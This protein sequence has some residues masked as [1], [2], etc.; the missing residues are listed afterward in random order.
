MVTA[1][2]DPVEIAS[3]AEQAPATLVSHGPIVPTATLRLVVAAGIVARLRLGA[4]AAGAS[5]E[6]SGRASRSAVDRLAVLLGL[7][8]GLVPTVPVIVLY[9][10]LRRTIVVGGADR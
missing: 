5:A 4:C 8:V 1:R 9:L 7:A 2:S 10:L 3:G 6:A